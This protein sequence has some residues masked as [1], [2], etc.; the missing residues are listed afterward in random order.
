MLL[1]YTMFKMAL[2]P[3]TLGILEEGEIFFKHS[4]NQFRTLDGLGT[5][6]LL[7]AVLVTRYPCKLPTDIQK[8]FQK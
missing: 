3:D 2:F 7:G 8:V 5:D 4:K 6:V 1:L